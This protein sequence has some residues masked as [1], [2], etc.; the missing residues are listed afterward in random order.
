MASTLSKKDSKGML[1]LPQWAPMCMKSPPTPPAGEVPPNE[2]T[3]LHLVERAENLSIRR[4]VPGF[5]L[6]PMPRD[7]RRT[8]GSGGRFMVG[9][10]QPPLDDPSS[11]R[12]PMT[13]RI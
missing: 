8:F 2:R 11:E 7:P 6:M 5:E 9:D 3:G 4:A 12:P 1:K 13:P 10:S